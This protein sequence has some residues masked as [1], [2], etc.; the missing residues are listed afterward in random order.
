MS[1]LSGRCLLV[2]DF[3]TLHPF[4]SKM[5]LPSPL[6]PKLSSADTY[7]EVASR[8][9]LSSRCTVTWQTAKAGWREWCLQH[10]TSLPHFI[11][12]FASPT[13]LYG[14]ASIAALRREFSSFVRTALW[15]FDIFQP[16]RFLLQKTPFDLPHPTSAS[17]TC[18]LLAKRSISHAFTLPT[19]PTCFL[20]PPPPV[21][22]HPIV[23]K[24]PL[25]K[26][27]L[28]GSLLAYSVKAH[29]VMLY[30]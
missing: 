22:C 2:N 21:R 13:R 26:F 17:I 7:A 5:I 23:G 9:R 29:G 28:C 12:T 10:V 11:L 14:S 19:Q 20:P 16:A 18:K 25:D 1:H 24:T 8:Q 4:C 30:S 15:P 6:S 27:S 3:H